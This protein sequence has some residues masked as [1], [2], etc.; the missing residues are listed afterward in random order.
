[1]TV[2]GQQLPQFTQFYL[3]E[4][5]INPG[6]TG[7]QPYWVG[8][9]N[10]RYQWAGIED[11]PRTYVLSLNGP[12]NNRKVGLGGY[13]FTDIVGPTRRTGFN[14]SYAYHLKINDEMT[15]GMGVTAGVLQFMIDGS[16]ITTDQ[17]D[18]I[19][20]SNG[21]QKVVTPDAGVG[22]YLNSEEFF[23][24]LSAPQLIGNKIQFFEDYDETDARLERHF[25]AYGGYRFKVNDDIVVEPATFVKYVTPTPVQFEFSLRGIY[26]DQVWAGASYRMDDAVAFTVGYL[27]QQNLMFGYSFDM[28]TSNIGNHS[29]GTHE[30]MLGIRFRQRMANETE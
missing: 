12:L 28:T 25:F 6:Y 16:K 23:I 17:P 7:S 26:K 29:S 19:A 14:A 10:N 13:L 11:A 9:S 2:Y 15:L 20:I 22:F 21:L 24:G 1:M 27:F 5:I 4:F 8:Q 3:S 30:L 18:D